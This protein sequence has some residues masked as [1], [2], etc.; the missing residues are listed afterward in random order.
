MNTL[1]TFKYKG[2][3]YIRAVPAKTLFRSTLIHEVVNRGDVFAIRVSDQTLTIIPGT[4]DVE[5]SIHAIDDGTSG[6][7][8]KQLIQAEY[9][10]GHATGKAQ[11]ELKLQQF[12]LR[13]KQLLES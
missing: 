2:E 4:A 7:T 1:K 11:G 6:D 5:H 10:K 3:L 9:A 12:K 8:L 13:L